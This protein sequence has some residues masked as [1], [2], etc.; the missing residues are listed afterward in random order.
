MSKPRPNRVPS[1]SFLYGVGYLDLHRHRLR[2]GHSLGQE[3]FQ[4]R[5]LRLQPNQVMTPMDAFNIQIT[6]ATW[7][8]DMLW[9]LFFSAGTVANW[10]HS[11]VQS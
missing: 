1:I 6:P 5:D 11:A 2:H 9:G 7:Q 3:S 8:V 4:W 10:Q